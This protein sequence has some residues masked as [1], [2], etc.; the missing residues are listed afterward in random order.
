[1]WK[2]MIGKA[3]DI[4]YETVVQK[5]AA[6]LANNLGNKEAIVSYLE[7]NKIPERKGAYEMLYGALIEKLDD[8]SAEKLF[9]KKFFFVERQKLSVLWEEFADA[10]AEIRL[11]DEFEKLEKRLAKIARLK[12]SFS[13]KEQQL[14][15]K[16]AE[17][18]AQLGQPTVT[19]QATEE[20]V[21][22]KEEEKKEEKKEPTHAV[23]AA[24]DVTKTNDVTQES[25]EE[26]LE[27][28]YQEA[29]LFG[30]NVQ[31]DPNLREEG[32]PQEPTDTIMKNF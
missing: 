32:P 4:A 15:I 2:K 7:K 26:I 28:L 24:D 9:A 27:G 5:D 1:M 29:Q 13:T 23:E 3:K 14:Q 6:V 21:S 18:L 17:I 12:D 20:K 31:F 25:Q 19:E 8:E 10:N 22:Q 30:S 16:R 11:R